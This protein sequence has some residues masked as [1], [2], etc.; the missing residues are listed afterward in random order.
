MEALMPGPP[1]EHPH[2]RLLKGN[3]GKRRARMPPEAKQPDACPEPPDRLS[4]Y[5]KDEWHA[6]AP[7]L[8][9]LGLLTVVD[10]S[11]FACYCSAAGRVRAAEEAMAGEP[12]TYTTET[13]QQRVNPLIRLASTAMNDALKLGAHFGLTPISRLRL[14]GMEPPKGK[15]KFGGLIA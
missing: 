5:A 12:L 11:A 10:V 1:P 15:S 9:R 7:E 13:G 3:P 6:V 4:A 14:T 8:F 2:L